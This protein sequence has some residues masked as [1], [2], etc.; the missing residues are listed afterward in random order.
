MKTTILAMALAVALLL[1][2]GTGMAEAQRFVPAASA[3][4]PAGRVG[5]GPGAPLPGLEPLPINA[6]T[7]MTIAEIETA[8][9]VRLRRVIGFT[10]RTGYYSGT[11]F[12]YDTPLGTV[13]NFRANF[14]AQQQLTPIK[15]NVASPGSAAATK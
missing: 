1:F 9:G 13:Y 14:V 12:E 6:G 8:P 10:P 11:V 5:F 4:V 3:Y 2:A 7:M 15:P